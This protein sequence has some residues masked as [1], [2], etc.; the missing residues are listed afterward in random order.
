M[1][2]LER[3][4]CESSCFNRLSA[5]IIRNECRPWPFVPGGLVAYRSHHPQRERGGAKRMRRKKRIALIGG[6]PTAV[7]TLKNLLQ[8]S[9]ELEITLFEAGRI[10]GCG[11]P[12]SPEHNTPDMMANIT[13]VEIPPVL[14]SLADWVRSADARFLKTFGIERDQVGERDYYPRILIGAY[15]ID[16][17]ERMVASSAPWHKVVIET[18]TRVLDI[19]PLGKS[20]EI[21]VRKGS[22]NASRRFD[23]VVMATGH[24]SEPNRP[25]TPVQVES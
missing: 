12:Y 17:L 3:R 15:Y 18:E 11:I 4:T 10:A 9:D 23:A 1:L 22:D 6:G 20:F 19:K 13:S 8:K 25:A 5:L 7:Y 16:Q 24:L 2:G 21:M 14:V